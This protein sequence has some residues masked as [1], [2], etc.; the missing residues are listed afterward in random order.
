LEKKSANWLF[1]RGD[2]GMGVSTETGLPDELNGKTLWTYEIQGGG[3]P[4][5]AGNKVYQFGYYGSG[6]GVEE[7]LTCLDIDSGELIWDKRRQ[8]FI[9]DIV[10]DR[11]GVG[12]ACVD[13]QTGNIFFQTSPGLLAGFSPDGSLL[14]ERSLMEEFAR[15][16]FPNGRTGGRMARQGTG[17][18]RLIKIPANWSGHPPL[19]P[20][21][22]IVP[23]PRSYLRIW[24]TDGESF[25][26]VPGAGMWCV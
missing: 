10:Y 19:V 1:V 24:R 8:D 18:M 11:Y 16:T 17:F 7:S 13:E 15:L 5:V 14:W 12:S 26:A 4:V 23:S 6:E 2:Q 25:T 20:L 9:S 21:R 22:R 3:I